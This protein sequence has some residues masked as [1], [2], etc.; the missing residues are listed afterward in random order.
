LALDAGNKRRHNP[1]RLAH[2]DHSD[3]R[4]I[5]LESG[6]GPARVK[7]TMLRHGGAPSV[8]V[9]QR[10]RCH[11]LAARPIASAQIPTHAPSNFVGNWTGSSAGLV[12]WSRL[13]EQIF[14]IDK[15]SLCRG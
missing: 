10:R 6:Q 15:W 1:L 14:R 11:A 9:K 8:T 2:L 12:K 13:S 7:M 4:V 3:D 5:L